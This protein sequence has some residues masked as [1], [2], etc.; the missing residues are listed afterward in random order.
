MSG[1]GDADGDHHHRS[2]RP[3]ERPAQFEGLMQAQL[4]GTHRAGRRQIIKTAHADPTG[5]RPHRGVHQHR[6]RGPIAGVENRGRFRR[7]RQHSHTGTIAVESSHHGRTDTVVAAEAVS[8]SDHSGVRCS[9]HRR[10]T[11]RVRKWVE[12]EMHGS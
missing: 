7:A 12:H 4:M 9:A 2:R 10:F 5:S 1:V 3:A 11:V 6:Q 8:D